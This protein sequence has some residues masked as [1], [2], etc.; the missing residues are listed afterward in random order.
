MNRSELQSTDNAG[1]SPLSLDA[2]AEI[3]ERAAA[4]DLEARIA[5]IP[6]DPT[7]GRLCRAINHLLDVSAPTDGITGRFFSADCPASIARAPGS[8]TR[9]H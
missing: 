9:R 7:V 2:I 3:C 8:S 1:S 4:G 5:G 6:E